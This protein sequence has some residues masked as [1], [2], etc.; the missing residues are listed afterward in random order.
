M[1]HTPGIKYGQNLCMFGPSEDQP[2]ALKKCVGMWWDEEIVNYPGTDMSFTADVF[3]KGV[4]HFTQVSFC[5]RFRENVV[6]YLKIH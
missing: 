1:K 5:N 3:S 6:C 4:G 2:A